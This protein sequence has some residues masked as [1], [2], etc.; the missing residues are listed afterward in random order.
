MSRT[1]KTNPWWVGAWWEPSH[2]HSCP[3]YRGWWPTTDHN[4]CD[5]PDQ[6]PNGPPQRR[7]AGTRSRARCTWWP[8]SPSPY[9]DAGKTLFGRGRH[10]RTAANLQERGIRAAW[11]TTARTLAGTRLDLVDDVALPDPRHRHY[12]LW[13]D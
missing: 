2:H 3:D 12:A 6:P 13:D 8:D 1:D 10:V 4:P 11:R 5:L 9:S 7:R